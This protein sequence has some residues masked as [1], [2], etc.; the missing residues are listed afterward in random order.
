MVCMVYGVW[1]MVCM[2][3]MACVCA[4]LC[5]AYSLVGAVIGARKQREGKVE[6]AYEAVANADS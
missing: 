5:C 1:C 4:V 2:A 3:C 6:R